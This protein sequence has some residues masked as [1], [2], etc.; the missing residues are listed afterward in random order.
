M[1]FLRLQTQLFCH[2]NKYSL[3]KSAE[4]WVQLDI[5]DNEQPNTLSSLNKD[6]VAG[7]NGNS[8]NTKTL[9]FDVSSSDYLSAIAPAPKKKISDFEDMRSVKGYVPPSS[10]VLYRGG[11]NEMKKK[12]SKMIL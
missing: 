4:K 9:Q 1:N 11:K 2:L 12:G 5:V 3:N 6:I 7:S 8:N 10:S